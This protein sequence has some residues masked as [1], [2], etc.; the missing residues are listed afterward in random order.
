LENESHNNAAPGGVEYRL[1]FQNLRYRASVRVVDFFPPKLEDFAA[2]YN[3]E[4]A[5]LS[6]GEHSMND[7]ESDEEPVIGSR[8]WEWRF[9][10]LVEDGGPGVCQHAM[11]RK[12]RMKLYVAG[13]DAVFL[14][15]MDA[16]K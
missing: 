16:V 12:E 5:M 7:D 14:L 6:D 8:I 2:Q 11:Q 15:R 4:Y 13:A 3:P 1:P 9:C 10:L